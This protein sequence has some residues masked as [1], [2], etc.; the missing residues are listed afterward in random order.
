MDVQQRINCRLTRATGAIVRTIW[1]ASRFLLNGWE[2][3]MDKSFGRLMNR[4]PR[5]CVC[6]I[7]FR[8]S[9]VARRASRHACK[10]WI[11]NCTRPTGFTLVELLVVIAIIGILIALLLPAVQAAREASRRTGCVNNLKQLG[12]ALLNYESAKKRLPSGQLSEFNYAPPTKPGNYFSVQT[13]ILSY[14]EEENIRQLFDLNKYV[15]DDPPNWTAANSLPNLMLC[16]TESQRGQPGDGGWS[17]YHANSGSWAQLKGW[18]G[19]FGAVVVE[20]GIPALPGL[21][22]AKIVDGTSNTAFL[23]EMVNGLA[24]DIAPATGGNPLA[25]CFEFGGNPIPP[26]GGALTLAQIRNIFLNKDWKT[27]SVPWSGE[28]RYRGTPWTEGTMWRTWY[29]HLLPPNSVC[30]HTD[31]WWKLISPASSYH[32]GVVNV[33]MVDGSVQNVSND[34]DVEI[35]TE[36]GTRNGRPTKN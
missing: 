26:G 23:A 2:I 7:G 30:W 6:R 5:V 19:V 10:P 21:R 28:W 27:A 8:N 11:G 12:L 20:D 16:P 17:N 9:S 36:M 13:Q 35:W 22:L 29:N 34:V 18:D 24:P 3:Q 32:P 14:F 31:S 33:A 25:D 1:Q 15:Y 4:T